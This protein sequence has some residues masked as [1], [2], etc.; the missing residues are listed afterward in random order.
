[1]TDDGRAG[2]APRWPSPDGWGEIIR[3]TRPTDGSL[4]GE[5]AVTSPHEVP[6]R[7]ARGRAVQKGWASLTAGD[8]VR[9]LRGLLE[10]LG[11]RAREIEETIVAETGKPRTEA[12]LE[13]LTV[14]DQ[15]RY[16][17]KNASPFLKPRR[18]STG[19]LVWK[20]AMMV[21]EPLGVIGVISPW[22]HPFVVSMTP[23]MTALFGGNAV[24]LK[25]SEHAP[26]TGLLAE[27]LAR[28][29]GLPND[30]VQVVVGGAATGEALVRGGVDKIFFTGGAGTA[31]SVLAAA[32]ES[33]TPVALEL[34]G[35]DAAVVLEDADLERAAR[36]IV[37]GAFMNAGQTCLSVERAYVVEEVFDAFLREVLAQVRQ[38]KV[39]STPGL[40]MGPMTTTAQLSLVEEHLADAVSRGAVVVAGGGRTD[41]ASNVLE[42]TVLTNLDPGSLV[43]TEETFGPL[44]PLIPVKDSE[45][46]V[47][48]ANGGDFGLS[49]SVWTRD[50]SRGLDM[51]RRIRAGSVCVND[52]LVHYAIP[53]L[54]FGGVGKSGYGRSKGL[55]GLAAL[56]RTRSVVTDWLGLKREPWWF[57]YSRAS[58]RL[59]RN[60]FLLRWKG[61]IRGLPRLAASFLKRAAGP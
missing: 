33:L 55:D 58:E 15:L 30:L 38:L 40:S 51:A 34:G 9:H 11:G 10:A 48:R 28:D 45:E 31:V 3:V 20:R 4:V 37:W 47:L 43:L 53:G 44:L 14:T 12:L 19:W 54:P 18:V 8:R 17:L 42:P 59:L 50:R 46:A 26:Y 41:P 16:Y 7:V 25:P 2:S 35:K 61:V 6:R 13:L 49:A 36:G 27:D 32:A 23:V 1:V 57:P 29:A 56:T 5:L 60:V 39:G 52:A 22:N 24:V 21:R